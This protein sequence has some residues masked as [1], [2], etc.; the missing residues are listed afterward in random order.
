MISSGHDPSEPSGFTDKF[1]SCGIGPT[2]IE[3]SGVRGSGEEFPIEL[4]ISL[5]RLG[6]KPIISAFVRDIS[7]HRRAQEARERLVAVEQE[8]SVARQIQQ[9]ILHKTFPAYPDRD[10]FDIY[11]EMIPAKE[12]GGDFYDFFLVEAGRLGVVIGDVSG[13]G[14]PAA[15]LMGGTRAILRATALQG[16]PPD[17]CLR[18]VNR[19]ACENRDATTFVSALYGVLDLRSGN[20]SFSNAGHNFPYLVSPG[21]EP[22]VRR[23]GGRTG[24]AL[25]VLPEGDFAVE[26][27]R[28]DPGD[29]IFLYTD[30]V[31]EAMDPAREMFEED[32][33]LST[34]AEG[35]SATPRELVARM[36]GSIHGF[37]RG[38]AQSDDITML[39]LRFIRPAG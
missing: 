14:V 36:T 21:K 5:V 15:I 12:V 13:K 11:A 29:A 33:L 9:A 32:R 28:M 25:G 24:I 38:A 3:T 34:L 31:T 23:I 22:Q 7:E 30:G 35:P 27:V 6:E 16:Q 18:H 19:L 39:A 37:T 10:D 17:D 8:L 2:R 26:T 20:F 1:A 4:S